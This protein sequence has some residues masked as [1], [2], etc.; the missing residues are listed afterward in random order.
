MAEIIHTN[1]WKKLSDYCSAF[2][3]A[4]TGPFVGFMVTVKKTEDMD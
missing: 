4:C 1:P 3:L 2:M